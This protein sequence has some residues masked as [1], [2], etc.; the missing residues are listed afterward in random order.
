MLQVKLLGSLKIDYFLFRLILLFLE[1]FYLLLLINNEKVKTNSQNIILPLLVSSVFS[2]FFGMLEF[3]SIFVPLGIFTNNILFIFII[4]TLE[5]DSVKINLTPFINLI[6][7]YGII[8]AIL[9]TIQYISGD[10]VISQAYLE[11]NDTYKSV[12]HYGEMV[13][14]CGLFTSALDVGVLMVFCFLYTLYLWKNSSIVKKIMLFMLSLLFAFGIYSTR[15]RNIYLLFSFALLYFMLMKLL[16]NKRI[17]NYVYILI[18]VIIAIFIILKGENFGNSSEVVSSSTS[19][20]IR[21]AEWKIW[22]NSFLNR[23]IFE[24]LFGNCSGQATG[25]VTD[26]I[27]ME[28]L[29]SFGIVGLIYFMRLFKYILKR[30]NSC[31]SY[32][33]YVFSAFVASVFAFGIFNLPNTFF[34]IYLPMIYMVMNSEWSDGYEV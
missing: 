31:L 25:I 34:M 9:C 20:G 14:S 13:R 4:F 7:C 8:N 28:Y 17:M 6:Y 27:Y 5:F 33:A 16:T 23:N 15:T 29:S 24:I 21:I 11:G 3:N 30:V 18:T 26:N 19:L 32:K 22:L 12:F 10:L 1:L 2:V